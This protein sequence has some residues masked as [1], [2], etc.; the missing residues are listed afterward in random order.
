MS[1]TLNIILIVYSSFDTCSFNSFADGTSRLPSTLVSGRLHLLGDAHFVWDSAL[2]EE[3]PLVEGAGSNA[4]TAST[5]AMV[6]ESDEFDMQVS[7]IIPTAAE[8]DGED[9]GTRIEQVSATAAEFILSDYEDEAEEDDAE[10]D[11]EE[12]DDEAIAAQCDGDFESEFD[13]SGV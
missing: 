1:H 13:E 2:Q 11:E 8:S 9:D 5:S 7:D 3:T 6:V 12:A 10:E 4:L